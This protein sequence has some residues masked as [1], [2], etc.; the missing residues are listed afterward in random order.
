[1]LTFDQSIEFSLWSMLCE[2]KMLFWLIIF[3]PFLFNLS[4]LNRSTR[5]IGVFSLHIR[6]LCNQYFIS[7]NFHVFFTWWSVHHGI[8]GHWIWKFTQ[9][10]L[11]GHVYRFHPNVCVFWVNP[12]WEN[13][14]Y[15][16]L[17]WHEWFHWFE[18]FYYSRS[19]L[20][21]KCWWGYCLFFPSLFLLRLGFVYWMF[22]TII[23]LLESSFTAS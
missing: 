20:L 23:T 15:G 16:L 18:Y 13:R 4:N 8:G 12:R 17:Q 6:P 11:Y 2:R 5:R 7:S 22:C 14:S 19:L 3:H 1:M 10:L 9:V 21:A